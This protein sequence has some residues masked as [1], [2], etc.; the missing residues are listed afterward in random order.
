MKPGTIFISHRAEYG[1]LVRE[2]KKSIETTSRGKIEAI[3]SEDLPGAEKWRSAIKTHLEDAESLFLVYGAAYED[4]SWCFYEAGYFAGLDAAE[5]QL[6]RIYCIARPDVSPPGPLND[7]QMVTNKERLITDLIE[8]YD[9]NNVDYDPV[10]LRESINQAAKGLFRKL[11]E[12]VS[13]PRVYVVAN[14]GD[15][16][17][18]SDLPA[19]TVIKGDT[20]VLTRLF[21][22]GKDEVPWSDIVQAG[23]DRTQQEL[24]FFSKW[25]EEMKRII[26]AA[27]QNRF[28]APQT[29]LVRGGQRVRFL[30]YVS[31]TQGD[32]VY[33]CEFLVIDEV[34]GPALG[35]SQQQLA[36]LTSLRMGFRFRYEFIK[37]F[38]ADPVELSDDERCVR[39]Q[40]TPQIIDNMM[41]ESDARG[42]VTLQ[43]LQGAFDEE[44][45]E[46][47]GTIVGYW[48]ALKDNLYSALGLSPDGK[49]VSTQGLVGPNLNKYQI[50]FEALRL[51]NIEFLSRC[52]AR[53]SR[54]MTRPEEELRRNAEVIDKNVRALSRLKVQPV[55][56]P[57]PNAASRADKP[58]V[59]LAP[60]RDSISIQNH[61][62]V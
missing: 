51:I 50:A 29:V 3:I 34:G 14:D 42:N 43:D 19:S 55:P 56:Q 49:V 40:E 18:C 37:R 8:I 22:I 61:A 12:F 41:I 45:A 47:I 9:R 28:L 59:P 38:A 27:R 15:F 7:L 26:L 46:R 60:P 57:D 23:A 16:S 62:Q 35:L 58:V 54:M 25:L 30:L 11:E 6:R 20:T 21:G 39:I 4:W 44:E 1:S 24:F 2:L 17:A 5:K 53:V 36:L 32:G 13:Y 10:K 48:P 31:R 52:C 33:C